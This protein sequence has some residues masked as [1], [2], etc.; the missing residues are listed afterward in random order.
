MKS[1]KKSRAG[2][3]SKG[4]GSNPFWTPASKEW[5]K[6]LWLPTETGCVG[7]PLN[8]SLG[9]SLISESVS[10]STVTRNIIQRP[11]S[12]MTSLKLSM[13]SLVDTTEQGGSTLREEMKIK[14]QKKK[15]KQINQ[16]AGKMKKKGIPWVKEKYRVQPEDKFLLKAK[17]IEVLPTCKE[18]RI[19]NDWIASFRKVYN[20]SCHMLNKELKEEKKPSEYDLR[21]RFVIAKRMTPTVRKQLEWTLRT[22]KRIREGA[23]KDLLSSYQSCSTQKRK[24]KI[25]KFKL[26]S[27]NRYDSQQTILISS[28]SSYIENGRLKTNGLKLRLRETI[29]D[30]SL[31]HNMRLMRIGGLYFICIPYS[32]S[33]DFIPRQSQTEKMVSIDPGCNVF[34]SFYSPQG[35]YGVAGEDWKDRLNTIYEKEEAIKGSTLSVERKKKALKKLQRI[36]IGMRDDFHWKLCYWYL[37]NFK[38]I[39]IPRL[40]VSKTRKDTK[41]HMKDMKHCLFVDRLIHVSRLYPSSRVFVCSERNSTKSCTLCLSMNTIAK[42]TIRCKSCGFEIHRDIGA[43]RTIFLVQQRT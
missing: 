33:L 27:K 41:R 2:L 36:I 26:K 9:C 30:C 6:K 5:S 11:T 28:D 3:T 37:D 21:D 12:Q 20:V 23:V 7:L 32:S 17:V 25:K 29:P 22:P 8:T 16:W 13:C 40:Y 14:Y 39:F 19:L 1:S 10:S 18:K 31:E 38:Y 15:Q 34:T 35:E 4:R 42:E 43:S 24:R